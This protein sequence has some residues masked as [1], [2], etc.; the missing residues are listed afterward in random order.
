MRRHERRPRCQPRLPRANQGF[1]ARK[2]ELNRERDAR[3]RA[4]LEARG[5]AIAQELEALAERPAAIASSRATLADELQKSEA[6]RRAAADALALADESRGQLALVDD[7]STVASELAAQ[8]AQAGQE[9]TEL[10]RTLT[11][12]REKAAKRLSAEVT[13]LLPELGMVDGRFDVTLV[14]ADIIT[15][16]GGESVLFTAA[17]NAGGELRPL[18]RVASGGELSRL[19]LALSTVLARLQHVPTLIFDEIDAGIGG[20]VAWQVGALMQ[21]V[22]EHHQVLAISHLAQIAAHADHHVAVQKSAVGTVTT[23]DTSV[24]HEDAR[25]IEI[26]RMLGGDA[27]REVSRAH[28]RELIE[29]GGVSRSRASDTRLRASERPAARA[30]QRRGKPV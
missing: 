22:A 18:D 10:S 5:T 25:M 11:K 7:A 21:R 28:A 14:P 2:F 17:L 27:D 23:A 24:L 13:S 20:S 30:G 19:M 12:Q 16:H 8:R 9:L 29:R 3:K 26:A 4:E 15:A 1:W 6:A